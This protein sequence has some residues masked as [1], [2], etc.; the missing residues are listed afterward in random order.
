MWKIALTIGTGLVMLT[1][2]AN[3][4]ERCQPV[5]ARFEITGRD[6]SLLEME[7]IGLEKARSNPA[8]P[9]VPWAYGHNNWLTFKSAFRPGD[10][11]RPYSQAFKLGEKPYQWGYALFRGNCLVLVFPVRI[12]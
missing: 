6:I 10:R 1:G 4:A 8:A 12:A 9:Q 2:M 7:R 5:D 3:A 11:V